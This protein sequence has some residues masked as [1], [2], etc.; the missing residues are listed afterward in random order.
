MFS[1]LFPSV[2]IC[3]RKMFSSVAWIHCDSFWWWIYFGPEQVFHLADQQKSKS[4]FLCNVKL[5]KN[6]QTMF[7]FRCTSRGIVSQS[8]VNLHRKLSSIVIFRSMMSWCLRLWPQS[9]GD[10]TST[11]ARCSSEQPLT[12]RERKTRWDHYHTCL[13]ECKSCNGVRKIFF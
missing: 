7:T 11:L 13:V 9:W 3:D 8:P 6:L 10:F 12:Q 5:H 1:F 4:W 2:L